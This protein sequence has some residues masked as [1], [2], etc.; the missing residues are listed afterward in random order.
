MVLREREADV[1]EHD[2]ALQL[3]HHC[4]WEKHKLHPYCWRW[5]LRGADDVRFGNLT[6]LTLVFRL[7]TSEGD[8]WEIMSLLMNR[9]NYSWRETSVLTYWYY[10]CRV[11]I[12]WTI[13]KL[14]V[15]SDKVCCIQQSKHCVCSPQC[16]QCAWFDSNIP[17][18]WI[19]WK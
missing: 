10:T 12:L 7:L 17:V 8:V 2:L 9:Y 11:C 16:T 5:N 19:K 15:T 6:L 4:L 1:W 18:W 14:Y 3:Q 13:C